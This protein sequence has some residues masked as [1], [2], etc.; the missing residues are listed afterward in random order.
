[1]TPLAAH[2]TLAHIRLARHT[3]LAT[4][5]HRV[6][7]ARHPTLVESD[8]AARLVA[9][10]DRTHAAARQLVSELP[11]LLR[12]DSA[13]LRLDD[14]RRARRVMDR[15]RAE[16]GAASNST[17]LEGVAQDFGRRLS[18]HQKGQLVR[19]GKAALGIE[20]VTF[21]PAIAHLVDGFVH[22]NVSLITSLQNRQLDEIEKLITRAIASGTRAE[23]V[24]VEIQARFGIGERHARLIAR[25]QVARLNSRITEAR[26]TELGI[27]SFLWRSMR[28]PKVRPE[29]VA[30]HG[31]RFR[32]DAPPAE[33]LPGRT[34]RPGCR[35]VPEPLFDDL[36]ALAAA[37]A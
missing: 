31:K 10:L 29:H 24:T 26:H 15:V 19:Q 32:Y 7:F 36:L 23:Q 34:R 13:E 3:G 2:Q 14:G 30:L 25:D 9:I 5:R 37:A 16:A 17:A 11:H 18:A 12:A 28:D 27:A 8:Y 22:E 21:D 1:V 33:G 6:P 20:L 4:R 35:C